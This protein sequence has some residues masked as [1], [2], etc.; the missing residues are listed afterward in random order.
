MIYYTIQRVHVALASI[1]LSLAG[2]PLL[3]EGG[4]YLRAVF[5]N[6]GELPPGLVNK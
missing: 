3:I 1:N 6:L 5:I 4:S 2:V